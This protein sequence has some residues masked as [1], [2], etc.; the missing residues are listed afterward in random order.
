MH[1]ITYACETDAR[2]DA[3]VRI[4]ELALDLLTIRVESVTRFT[5]PVRR[6]RGRPR[7]QQSAQAPTG[8]T[9]YWRI[10]Y[11]VADVDAATLEANLR[12]QATY[13]LIRTRDDDGH[14]EAWKISDSDLIPAYRRQYVIEQGFSW[15]KS[16]AVINPMYLHTP[17]RIASLGFIYCIG[18]MAWNLI[19][20]NARSYLKSNQLGLP[21]H[22]QKKSDHITT[23]F[24]FEIFASLGTATQQH[25]GRMTKHLV[26]ANGWIYLSLQALGIPEESIKPVQSSGGNNYFENS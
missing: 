19:Q 9:E 16:T 12:A 26:N 24:L 18:L 1:H 5:G 17:H 23:R 6:P 20:R 8:A 15:L 14:G 7:K 3:R 10:T 11:T 25:G 2:N 4:D 21:Y 22:Q 13:V